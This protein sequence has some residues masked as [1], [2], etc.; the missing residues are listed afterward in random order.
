M[1]QIVWCNLCKRNVT[2]EKE[3]NWILFLFSCGI[4]L[5]YYL[6]LK[7]SVCPVCHARNFSPYDVDDMERTIL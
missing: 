6:V 5:I 7:R 4:Y 3:F 1:A 2:P